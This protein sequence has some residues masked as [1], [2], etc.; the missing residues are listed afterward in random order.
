MI[1]NGVS[2]LYFF[3]SLQLTIIGFTL[4]VKKTSRFVEDGL[5]YPKNEIESAVFMLTL[6]LT[7]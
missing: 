4:F 1:V 7:R 6:N 3:L 2:K 5:F